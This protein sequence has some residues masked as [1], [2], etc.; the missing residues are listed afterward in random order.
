MLSIRGEKKLR[1]FRNL[2][3]LSISEINRTKV[4]NHDNKRVLFGLV[5][6]STYFLTTIM[7]IAW[8]NRQTR[9]YNGD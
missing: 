4:L 6:C 9:A 1:L 2:H 7:C 5:Q 8:P 3:F